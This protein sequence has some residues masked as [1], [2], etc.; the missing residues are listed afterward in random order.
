MPAKGDVHRSLELLEEYHSELFRSSETELK[1]AIERVINTFKHSLFNAL[2]DIHE[3]YENVLTNERIPVGD[4]IFESRRFAARWERSPILGP[5]NG[6]SQLP[7]LSPIR[8]P[9]QQPR[10]S[11]NRPPSRRSFGVPSGGG[12]DTFLHTSPINRLIDETGQEWE[13]EE[14]MLDVSKTGLGFSISGGRDRELDPVFGDKYIRVTDISPGGAV[15]KNGRLQIGDVILCVNDC[16]TA[17]CDHDYAVQALKDAGTYIRLLVKRL[18]PVVQPGMHRSL[19]Q[20]HMNMP[21]GASGSGGFQRSLSGMGSMRSAGGMGTLQPPIRSQ[22]L[23][24]LPSPMVGGSVGGGGTLPRQTASH[25][26][27]QI[28]SSGVK[29]TQSPTSM[30]EPSRQPRWVTLRKNEYGLGF[31]I[32]G[33]EDGEPI[34]I[35]HIMPGGAADLNGNIRKGDVLLQVNDVNLARATHGE[36][37]VALKAIPTGSQVQLLLQYRPREF[38]NFEERVER[39]RLQMQ[40]A[41]DVGYR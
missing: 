29:F 6:I 1:F 28:Q 17:N 25:Y 21:M 18:K 32:V 27:S 10:L 8:R 36:A 5:F 2:C 39:A 16:D 22:S 19:S 20:S 37:A 14:V 34:Y 9:I 33:G 38:F 15:Q 31:N 35:S 13:V 7:S 23:H 11:P 30:V 26:P 12:S 3:F 24:H 4:K 40:G 41:Q